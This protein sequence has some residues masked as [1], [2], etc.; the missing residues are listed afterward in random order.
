MQLL[1]SLYS[2]KPYLILPFTWLGWLG[3]LCLIIIG[4]FYLVKFREHLLLRFDKQNKERFFIFLLLISPITSGIIGLQF[5]SS[6]AISIPGAPIEIAAPIVYPFSSLPWMIALGT[7]GLL[8]ALILATLNGFIYSLWAAHQLFSLFEFLFLV[9]A[10]ILLINKSGVASNKSNSPLFAGIKTVFY[11]IPLFL[12]NTILITDGQ[13]LLRFDDWLKSGAYKIIQYLLPIVISG[14]LCNIGIKN[15]LLRWKTEEIERRVDRNNSLSNRF[16]NRLLPISLAM[17]AI[18][19]AVVWQL[20]TFLSERFYENRLKD[21]VFYAQNE[22]P[23]FFETG[24]KEINNLSN[25]AA[26]DFSLQNIVNDFDQNVSNS[27]FFTDIALYD[28]SGHLIKGTPGFAVDKLSNN[29]LNALQNAMHSAEFQI[30]TLPPNSNNNGVKF[31][32]VKPIID[33][34]NQIIGILSGYTNLSHNRITAPLV[35]LLNKTNL[36]GGNWYILDTDNRVLHSSDEGSIFSYYQGE[37]IDNSTYYLDRSMAGAGTYSFAQRIIGPNWLILLTIPSDE[38]RVVAMN[39]A[40]PITTMLIVFLVIFLLFWRFTL[41]SISSSIQILGLEA[42]AISNGNLTN[43]L[44]LDR[45]DE[46]GKLAG[47]LDIMRQKLRQRIDEMSKVLVVSNSV[48]ENL[49]FE[50]AIRPI[51]DNIIESDVYFGRICLVSNVVE[52]ELTDDPITFVSSRIANDYTYL[53]IQLMEMMRDRE[54]LDIPNCYRERRLQFHAEKMPGALIA[55]AIYYKNE[56]FGILWLGYKEPH[57]F[58]TEEIRYFTTMAGQASLAASNASLY[59]SAHVGKQRLES[60][61]NAI[62]DPVFVLDNQ[63]QIIIA[64]QAAANIDGSSK[65]IKQGQPVQ[66]LISNEKFLELLVS[67]RDNEFED[68]ITLKDGRVFSVRCTSAVKTDRNAGLICV[69]KDVTYY[70]TIDKMRLEF[71]ST[72]SHELKTP[73]SLLKGYGT[74]IQMVGQLNERQKNYLDQMTI[75]LEGLSRLVN[76]LLDIDRLESGEALKISNFSC[77][78]LLS[79]AYQSFQPVIAQNKINFSIIKL[80]K[81]ILLS[82]DRELIL[83][84]L[85]NLIENAIRFTMMN[86]SIEAGCEIKGNSITFFVGDTGKG[87]SPID[88]N[89]IFNRLHTSDAAGETHHSSLGLSIV[90]SIVKRHGGKVNAQSQLG[91]GS[92]FSF[93]LPMK[94]RI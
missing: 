17:F 86:G 82:A 39:I 61:L 15:D 44:D 21:L 91:K 89:N 14:Y 81:D 7:L 79:E 55:I 51:L 22:L 83:R 28:S 72:V 69:L 88:L 6:W 3:L 66:Y 58:T 85:S 49:N 65:V 90:N 57:H 43:Q 93:D 92:Y 70:K 8:P 67:R 10:F 46:L 54:Y 74:M 35:S 13:I 60:V 29:E 32:F 38:T 1:L 87:I 20:S 41:N 4:L 75:D 34:G 40:W 50:E 12:F 27:H 23:M 64:N 71:V 56:F 24:Q 16:F 11:L 84:A 52:G 73:L 36:E 47:S 94:S 19:V 18:I 62:P 31:N 59:Y 78:E 77:N 33:N 53:D 42:E 5:P 9:F 30:I 26:F 80:E 63:N 37:I 68:E 45:K 76:N 25:F 2:N 48:A